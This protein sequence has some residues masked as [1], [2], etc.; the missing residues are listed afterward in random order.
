MADTAAITHQIASGQGSVG[1]AVMDDHM[2]ARAR[3]A[4]ESAN[5]RL[6]EVRPVTTAVGKLT[7]TGLVAGGYDTRSHSGTIGVGGRLG[8]T[9]DA[10]IEADLSHRSPARGVQGHENSLALDV[11]LVAGWLPLSGSR[12][13]QRWSPAIAA[14]LIETEPGAYAVL[15]VWRDRLD[16]RVM[17]RAKHHGDSTDDQR[18]QGAALVRATADVRVWR[19]LWVEGGVDDLANAPGPWFGGRLELR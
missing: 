3:D 19:G 10:F 1:S 9:D 12:V 14:G 18:E 7:V 4:I 15:P 13:G 5:A 16:L 2:A 6:D 11:T 17:A 8:F